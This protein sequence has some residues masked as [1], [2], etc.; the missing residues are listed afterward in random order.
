VLAGIDF[1][2]LPQRFAGAEENALSPVVDLGWVSRQDVSEPVWK[3]ARSTLKGEVS[4]PI[5]TDSGWTI[6]QVVDR[7]EEPS[8]SLLTPMI[9]KRLREQNAEDVFDRYRDSLYA[10]FNVTF[11]NQLR[12]M[13]LKPK[14]MRTES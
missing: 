8:L 2:E 9:I 6:I 1:Y 7:K 5:A 13:H 3:A 11:P 4:P 14:S 12:P 10:E